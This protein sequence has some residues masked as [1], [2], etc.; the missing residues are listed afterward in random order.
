MP[1][2]SDGGHASRHCHCDARPKHRVSPSPPF[3]VIRSWLVSSQ[4]AERRL[5]RRRLN[6][7]LL[8]GRAK[9]G[10]IAI[11]EA[12]N[13]ISNENSTLTAR[14]LINFFIA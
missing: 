5:R 4:A 10:D 6:L 11:A 3:P 13:R 8:I 9:R 12:G 14:A 2:V 7:G 1:L